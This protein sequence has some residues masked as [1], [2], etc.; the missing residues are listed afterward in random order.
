MRVCKTSIASHFYRRGLMTNH[1][2]SLECIKGADCNYLITTVIV[3]AIEGS[4]TIPFRSA[5]L[6]E[7]HT[8]AFPEYLS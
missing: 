4:A 1:R 5:G 8:L 3:Q 7:E 2:N 6:R